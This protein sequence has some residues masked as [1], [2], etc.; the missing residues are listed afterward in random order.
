M[1]R[2]DRRYGPLSSRAIE[3]EETTYSTSFGAEGGRRK[4]RRMKT[5][6]RVKANTAMMVKIGGWFGRRATTMWSTQEAAKLKEVDPQPDELE[7]IGAYYASTHPEIRPYR[8]QSV[9]TLLNNW[10]KD[11]DKARN[12]LEQYPGSGAEVP[13][14]AHMADTTIV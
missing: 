5:G 9:E 14:V 13:P 11:L 10:T 7:I 6:T 4:G 3:E 2:F 1:T 8:R 12:K